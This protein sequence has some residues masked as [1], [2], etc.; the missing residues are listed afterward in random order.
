[1]TRVW[2]HAF[3]NDERV[4][5]TPL[6]PRG[7]PTGLCC[8]DDLEIHQVR[9]WFKKVWVIDYVYCGAVDTY[10]AQGPVCSSFRQ[11]QKTWG[12]FLSKEKAE[13][14]RWELK[15]GWE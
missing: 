5:K 13:T 1:M 3:P 7:N 12:P 14:K 4:R 2:Q 9:K 6:P 15:D 11:R 10:D 8:W